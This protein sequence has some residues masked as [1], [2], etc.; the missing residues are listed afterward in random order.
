MGQCSIIWRNRLEKYV[1]NLRY[2]QRKTIIEIAEIIQKEKKIKISRESIRRFL[3][4]K[5]PHDN[6]SQTTV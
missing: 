2:N 3:L 5:K 6:T 1:L 4:S